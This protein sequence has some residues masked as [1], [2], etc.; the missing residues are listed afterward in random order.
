M[1]FVPDQT[2]CR[3]LPMT[4]RTFRS[5][6]FLLITAAICSVI[7]MGRAWSTPITTGDVNPLTIVNG[8]N[9]PYVNVGETPAFTP[10]TSTLQIGAGDD[11]SVSGVDNLFGAGFGTQRNGT[12]TVSNG[13]KLRASDLRSGDSSSSGTGGATGAI[14]VTGPG[15]ET[16]VSSDQGLFSDNTN[17]AGFVRVGRLSGATGSDSG[18]LQVLNGGRLQISSGETINTTT[19]GPQLQFARDEGSFG[20]GLVDGSGSVINIF[21]SAP[22][23]AEN[24]GPF[25]VVGQAGTGSL[26]IRNDALVELTGDDASVAVGRGDDA[27]SLNLPQSELQ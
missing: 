16:I 9:G 11:V 14:T 17:E 1:C 6:S 7:G 10:G 25:L 13:G 2:F 22:A 18:M 21:Q 26:T 4:D 3:G 23:D 20:T 12:I 15:S 19:S 5:Y 24:G 8:D 27:A